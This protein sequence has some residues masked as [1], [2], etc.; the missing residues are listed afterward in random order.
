MIQNFYGHIIIIGIGI[1][2]IP[3]LVKKLRDIRLQYLLLTNVDKMKTDVDTVK[4]ILTL[5][6][7]IKAAI[8]NQ[9]ED[10]LLIDLVNRHVLECTNPYCCCKNEAILYDAATQKFSQ[11]NG[12]IL[13][14]E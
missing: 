10:I 13:I 4:Q 1:A 3:S 11:R 8:A 5:Q 7:M 2:I 12:K 6:E 14:F 9:A